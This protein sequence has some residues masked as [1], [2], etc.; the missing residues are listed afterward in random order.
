M[1]GIYALVNLFS[2]NSLARCTRSFVLRKQINA[3]V[4]TMRQH[5][6]SR[7]LYI[8]NERME[9]TL[10]NAMIL[11]MLIN[12]PTFSNQYTNN[13]DISLNLTYEACEIHAFKLVRF[14]NIDN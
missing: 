9:I 4:N 10:N 14:K 7:N 6:P 3:C 8:F 13:S 1:Y 2:L 11:I 12:L 5:L